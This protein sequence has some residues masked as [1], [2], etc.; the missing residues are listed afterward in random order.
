[1]HCRLIVTYS[2]VRLPQMQTHYY[3]PVALLS[4]HCQ[5]FPFTRFM[6]RC[7][8]AGAGSLLLKGLSQDIT[9]LPGN[10]PQTLVYFLVVLLFCLKSNSLSAVLE[11]PLGVC[12]TQF[13]TQ[14][15]AYSVFQSTTFL[16]PDF[17]QI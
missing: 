14:E 5:S 12:V 16:V 15:T 1:M 8:L 11:T 9:N 4:L 17:G 2:V 13:M 10:L 7:R 6:E 3:Y